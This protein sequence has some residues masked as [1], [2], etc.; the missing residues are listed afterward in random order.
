VKTFCRDFNALLVT[1]FLG[2]CNDNVL[3]N[4]LAMQVVAGGLWAG[5]LGEGGQGIVTFLFTLP[6]I[7][8]SG[9]SGQFADRH[10]KQKVARWMKIA[11]IPIAIGALVALWTTSLWAGLAVMFCLAA[12]STI[13]GPAK[14]G[15]IPDLV[16]EEAL[17]RANGALN[18][19]TNIAII[20][21]IVLGGY[22]SD[23]C[24]VRP[25]VPGVVMCA[26][27][28]AGYAASRLL[29]VLP[30]SDPAVR[31]AANPFAPYAE[32]LRA[33]RR[34]RTMLLLALA[35]SFFYFIAVLII[36]AIP[37]FKA[38]LGLERDYDTTLLMVPLSV[39]IG[40]GSALAGW[41]TN[42]RR[43]PLRLAPAGAA[44]LAVLCL[45]LG[46]ARLAPAEGAAWQ[47]PAY[48]LAAGYLGAAGAFGGV[49]IVPFYAM[50]Q[51]RAPVELRGRILGTTNFLNFLFIGI[52]G[53]L[54]WLLQSVAGQDAQAILVDAAVM[55]VLGCALLLW[56]LR[57][58]IL[59]KK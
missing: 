33:M 50:L 58:H 28:L 10:S 35:T 13:F 11:E 57:G 4:I 43:A 41:L 14:Y 30:P 26:I 1:Q 37:D 46:L 42:E 31:Y 52:A 48:R 32:A 18:M 47:N 34:D 24:R 6:F 9:W 2:A 59:G 44:G 23:A 51:A 49:F 40:V 38:I 25:L 22:L 12:Q 19:L 8:F 54:Y 3:K 36:Q 5:Q 39:G 20:A 21:G 7:L 53:G 15:M 29:P 27:A 56:P 55:T 17:P 45:L 16:D